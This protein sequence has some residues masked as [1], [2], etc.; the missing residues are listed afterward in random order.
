MF[1]RFLIYIFSYDL[2][3]YISHIILHKKIFYDSIHYIHHSVYYKKMTYKDAY[4]GHYLES[5]IQSLG[6]FVP[7]I[8]IEFVYLEFILVIKPN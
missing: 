6:I 2:W 8:F 5:I 4:K 3:F 1:I 7:L